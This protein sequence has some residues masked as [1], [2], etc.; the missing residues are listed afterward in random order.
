[1]KRCLINLIATAVSLILLS[2][3]DNAHTVIGQASTGVDTSYIL[4]PSP[5]PA[6]FANAQS[7]FNSRCL[8]CHGP[9]G[10]NGE[11][12]LTTLIENDFVIQGPAS[13]GVLYRCVNTT[14]CISRDGQAAGNMIGFGNLTAQEASDILDYLEDIYIRP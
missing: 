3:C 7:A 5:D 10:S 1:M 4:N 8:T 14:N 11:I 13:Q 12:N 9:G 2:A 6:L